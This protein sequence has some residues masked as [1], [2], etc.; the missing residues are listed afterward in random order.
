MV[1]FLLIFIFL[2]PFSAP[3]PAMRG[4]TSPYG[5]VKARTNWSS[6]P[7]RRDGWCAMGIRH[8]WGYH[9]DIM[10]ISAENNG[11]YWDN[12]HINHQ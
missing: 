2:T 7:S 12:A 11:K 9:G 10:G 6:G 1:Y 5:A 4:S 8:L 3:L